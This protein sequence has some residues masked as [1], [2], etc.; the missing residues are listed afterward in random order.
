APLASK[1]SFALEVA[2]V[3]IAPGGDRPPAYIP[4]LPAPVVPGLGM[5]PVLP[6]PPPTEVTVSVSVAGLNS[7]A[8]PTALM[9]AGN[10]ISESFFKII[11]SNT[12]LIV[13]G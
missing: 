2:G 4:G 12:I 10:A 8:N 9:V 5:L 1:G 13:E 3:L 6:G 11:L 7:S